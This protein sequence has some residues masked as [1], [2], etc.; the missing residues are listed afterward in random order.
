MNRQKT[1]LHEWF[2]LWENLDFG[3][4]LLMTNV[5][6]TTIFHLALETMSFKGHFD[7]FLEIYQ[8]RTALVENWI[9]G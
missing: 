1:T 5:F 9:I 3:L 4:F 7:I 6:D 8:S 2:F